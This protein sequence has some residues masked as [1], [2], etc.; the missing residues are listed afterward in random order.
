[1]GSASKKKG[2]KV[3]ASVEFTTLKTKEKMVKLGEI[4][5]EMLLMKGGNSG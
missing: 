2:I 1:M 5:M 4:Q 3:V